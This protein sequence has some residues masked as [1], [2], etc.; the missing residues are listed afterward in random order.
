MQFLMQ[1]VK[2][3]HQK[4]AASSDGQLSLNCIG[5]FGWHCC[6][7]SSYRKTMTQ[8][9]NTYIGRASV[10]WDSYTGKDLKDKEN[11]QRG[12]V[13]VTQQPHK[14]PKQIRLLP[15]LI[16]LFMETWASLVDANSP[17][18]YTPRG[19]KVQIL[20]FPMGVQLSWQSS[21]LLIYLSLVQVQLLPLEGSASG[22]PTDC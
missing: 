10:V 2:T 20:L 14:L 5:A 6:A 8:M 22:M 12:R 19:A 7:G 15:P 1:S 11:T 3:T 16:S 4:L 9:D 18:N 13:T 21:R 17:E